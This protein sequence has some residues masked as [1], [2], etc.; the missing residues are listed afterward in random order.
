MFPIIS[1]NCSDRIFLFFREYSSFLAGI[2]RAI[3]L[4]DLKNRSVPRM[5]LSCNNKFGGLES[6]GTNA[7]LEC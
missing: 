3:I 6:F 7:R 2:F 4:G 1:N 5:R